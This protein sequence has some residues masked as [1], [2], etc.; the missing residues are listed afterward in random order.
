MKRL[1]S[2]RGPSGSGKTT[3]A[4]GLSDS[5]FSA[6]DYYEVGG[7]G[8]VPGQ[9]YRESWS[10]AKIKKAHEWNASRLI[11]AMRVGVSVV[12][13]DNTNM[14]LSATLREVAL[15]AISRGYT[16]QIVEPAGSIWQHIKS[17]L[18][19]KDDVETLID[20]IRSCDHLVR[21]TVHGVP[22]TSVLQQVLSY[23]EYTVEE[24]TADGRTAPERG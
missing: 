14:A 3:I 19:K 16:I 20:I 21:R 4:R 23:R 9:D 5:V 15:T 7:P 22:L 12:V 18:P 6:D 8:N 13:Y 24:L 1:I 11:E 10:R 17:V 2:M